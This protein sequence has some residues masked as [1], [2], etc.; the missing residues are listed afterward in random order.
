MKMD[1]HI[2]MREANKAFDELLRQK[3][4][5]TPRASEIETEFQKQIFERDSKNPDAT[6]IT[7]PDAID[8]HQERD[9]IRI[10]LNY[11]D[12]PVDDAATGTLGSYMIHS[13][14]D[15]M[16]NFQ[17]PLY[18]KILIEYKTAIEQG[19]PPGPESFTNHHDRDIQTLAIELL[20]FPFEYASWEEHDLP[21]Q[22]QKHPDENYMM[23]AFHAILRFKLKVIMHHID[24]NMEL[25]NAL[26]TQGDDEETI[27]H[28]RMH[29]DLI[30]MRDQIT[31]QF[32]S[33]VLKV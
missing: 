27:I 22:I 9:I 18:R 30:Q 29:N 11:G 12:K 20:S 31:A 23:D 4:Q 15:V 7:F 14:A 21:F 10:L 16:E 24:Q 32:K 5:G 3:R 6:V 8:Q 13:L 26:R 33:V 19:R 17:N 1:E 28:L 2:L 25:I